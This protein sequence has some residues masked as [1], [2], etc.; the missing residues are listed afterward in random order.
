ML[1]RTSLFLRSHYFSFFLG[2]FF[3]SAVR[4]PVIEFP[5]RAFLASPRHITMFFVD[6]P[7]G[8]LVATPFTSYR[9]PPFRPTL[10]FLVKLFGQTFY[11]GPAFH[12]L[13]LQSIDLPFPLYGSRRIQAHPNRFVFLTTRFFIL[14]VPLSPAPPLLGSLDETDRQKSLF[15][16]GRLRLLEALPSPDIGP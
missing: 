1:E 9:L 7:M 8:K 16:L 15:S 10:F 3:L 13:S 6:H 11:R 14:S 5:S 2:S 12:N 4:F